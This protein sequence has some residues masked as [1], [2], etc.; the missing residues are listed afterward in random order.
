MA[1]T[2]IISATNTGIQNTAGTAASRIP[3]KT[4]G[5]DAFLGLLVAQLT[6]QD[7]L[8]PMKDTEFVSQMAQFTSLEQTKAMQSDISLM[9]SQQQML[10][11]MSLLGR[12]ALVQSKD[13]VPITGVV[14]G[15]EMEGQVPKL[16]VGDR[17]YDLSDIISIRSANQIAQTAN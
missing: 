17:K 8:D 7:P 3:I 13:G 12:E 5:Q 4:L 9:R 14:G 16:I 10:Q 1:T 11:A 2:P 15:F 6:H